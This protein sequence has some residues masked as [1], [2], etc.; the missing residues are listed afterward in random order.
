MRSPRH[1][2]TVALGAYSKGMASGLPARVA[3][4]CAVIVTAGAVR[5][6]RRQVA[7]IDL[8][9]ADASRQLIR[10]LHEQL[11][12]HFELQPLS[13]VMYQAALQGNFEDEDGPHVSAARA[14]KQEAEDA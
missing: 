13:S 14:A 8:T 6:E 10:D 3:I 5:A 4:V 2:S 11:V 12:D 7:I 9:G 1:T